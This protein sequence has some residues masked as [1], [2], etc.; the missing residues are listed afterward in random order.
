MDRHLS[1]KI[2][3]GMFFMLIFLRCINSL[4]HRNHTNS[5]AGWLHR[6]S[7]LILDLLCCCFSRSSGKTRKIVHPEVSSHQCTFHRA[8][9]FLFCSQ[10]ALPFFALLPTS[11]PETMKLT[12]L[13]IHVLF[14]YN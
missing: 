8:Q 5:S 14:R 2:S 7:Y 3:I 1:N 10:F 4:Q 11:P 9:Y 12:K 6:I 13:R